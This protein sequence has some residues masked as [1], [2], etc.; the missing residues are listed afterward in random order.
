MRSEWMVSRLYFYLT[1]FFSHFTSLILS[2]RE[3]DYGLIINNQLPVTSH[4]TNISN[5]EWII[6]QELLEVSEVNQ[7]VLLM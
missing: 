3:E 5:L 4:T 6:E 7:T 1:A 2:S